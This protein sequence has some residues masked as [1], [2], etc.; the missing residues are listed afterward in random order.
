MSSPEFIPPMLA[1]LVRVLPEGREWEYELKLDGYRLEAVK[2][3]DKV[4]LYSRRGND[5]TKKF[6][7]IAKLVSR[8]KAE[9][10][11]LDGEAVA[12]DAKGKP[13]FQM[14]QNRSALPQG[15]SLAY[16]AFD[17]LHLNGQDLKDRPLSERR[18]LLE[19]L[20][21]KS[22]VLFSQSMPGTLSQIIEAVKAH[23]LEGIIAK[24]LDSKYHP[25]RRGDDW[26]KLPL[27][28]SERL[29]IGAYRLDGKRL[30]LLLVGY[31]EGNRFLFAG[32]VHQGLNPA[33]R[34]ALLKLL[35]PLAV[36]NCPFSNL[37]K[38]KSGH[39]GEGVTAE[40]MGDYVWLR[41]E[42]D[43]EIKFAEWT[44]GGVL[45]HAEFVA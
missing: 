19:K 23:G 27:K 35:E 40:E 2:D 20:P 21:G 39:W 13:S 16:Y 32:K 37:P 25:N 1:K 43:A 14:L 44:Q 26:L 45:R 5:S 7:G 30:E 22:G 3:G 36:L 11:V 34:R 28:P 31:W 38:T 33:N 10:F 6:A 17:L 9:S 18:G 15:W 24:R 12:V 42:F 4:R 8:I 41:P 29:I